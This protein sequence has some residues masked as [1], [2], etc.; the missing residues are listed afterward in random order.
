MN[1]RGATE[2]THSSGP[3]RRMARLHWAAWIACTCALVQCLVHTFN[4][5]YR[6]V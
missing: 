6:W 1:M 3:P 2:P 4:T 5:M